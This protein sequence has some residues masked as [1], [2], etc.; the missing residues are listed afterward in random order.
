MSVGAT[1]VERLRRALDGSKVA[2]HYA[3]MTLND[4]RKVRNA[5]KMETDE[6]GGQMAVAL[7]DCSRV[8]N[9][10]DSCDRFE[11]V[12]IIMPQFLPLW[13]Q[14]PNFEPGC[15]GSPRYVH[16]VRQ[17]ATI[18]PKS[19]SFNEHIR[20]L[21]FLHYPPYGHRRNIV[22]DIRVRN[23]TGPHFETR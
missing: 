9:S 13:R 1:Y 6:I 21:Q 16:I 3:R 5:T 22:P 14:I 11:Q 7:D 12:H 20:P 18:H 23:R 19:I 17:F 2:P 15:T 10:C 8:P 4:S